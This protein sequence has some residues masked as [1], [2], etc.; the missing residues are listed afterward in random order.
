M[1]DSLIH[2][3]VQGICDYCVADTVLETKN[4]E[5]SRAM[6][7]AHECALTVTQIR[8]ELKLKQKLDECNSSSFISLSPLFFQR[9]KCYSIGSPCLKCTMH[10]CLYYFLFPMRSVSSSPLL[11]TTHYG[12]IDC[13]LTNI[14]FTAKI[15]I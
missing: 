9:A 13:S 12:F 8:G 2:R 11:S 3:F 7:W 1:Y 10:L 15:H 14:Y 4:L 6:I 5:V